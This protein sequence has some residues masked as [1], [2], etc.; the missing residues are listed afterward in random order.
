MAVSG[1]ILTL[2]WFKR[3]Q[4]RKLEKS[5]FKTNRHSVLVSTSGPTF[6]GVT[7]LS[8]NNLTKI[9]FNLGQTA[10]K[11]RIDRGRNEVRPRLN[12]G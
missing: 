10:V 4:K 5:L 11:P 6:C 2:F 7:V 12:L 3:V 9:A 1:H 8:R